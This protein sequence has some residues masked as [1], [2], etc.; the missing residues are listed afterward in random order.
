M[1][2]NCNAN[3]RFEVTKR[4]PGNA[5]PKKK[6]DFVWKGKTD[7]NITDLKPSVITQSSFFF[8]TILL[9]GNSNEADCLFY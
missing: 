1:Y 2:T 9:G 5:N 8:R 7:R 6:M 4:T 3:F